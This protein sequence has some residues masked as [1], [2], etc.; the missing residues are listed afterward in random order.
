MYKWIIIILGLF[1]G[2]FNVAFGIWRV[3]TGHYIA[4]INIVTGSIV[5]Y[6]LYRN[7]SRLKKSKIG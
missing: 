2:T 4:L 7:I 6:K 1:I 5:F 3:S